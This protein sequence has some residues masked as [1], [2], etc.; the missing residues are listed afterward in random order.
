M[1][2]KI[3][4]LEKSKVSIKIVAFVFFLSIAI[5]APLLNQQ[6]ITGSIVNAVL[7]LSTAYLG[8]T[9]GI[10]L[11]FIPSLFASSYGLLPALFLPMIP[12][13]ILSNIMLVAIF[14]VLMKKNFW[15]GA[16]S[17]S[18]IKFLF[19]FSASSYIINFFIQKSLPA[20]IVVMMTWPQLTTALIGSVIVFTILKIKNEI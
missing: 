17:A 16:V 8:L 1:K 11:S 15:F 7:L 14:W 5:L 20:K 3:I 2:T 18:V 13:I 19:L 4:T 6:I 12:Y 9:S 10:L